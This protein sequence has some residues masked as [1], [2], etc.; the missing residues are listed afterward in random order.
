MSEILTHQGAQ[1]VAATARPYDFQ[2]NGERLAGV[3]TSLWLVIDFAEAPIQVKVQQKDRA[4]FDT[5]AGQGFGCLLDVAYEVRADGNRLTR[6]LV[7]A[8][9]S[10]P[11]QRKASAA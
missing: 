7:S 2:K 5:I 4:A 1:L 9:A 10:A 6:T 8:E 3:S 11:P